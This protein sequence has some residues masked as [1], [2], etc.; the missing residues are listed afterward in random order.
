MRIDLYARCFNEA[1]M[2]PFFFLHYDSLVQR[3]I[4]YDDG[5][6]DSSYELMRLNSKVEVRPM[7][8]YSHPDSRI[9]SALALQDSCW[10]ESRGVADWVIVTDIDEHLYHPDLSTY[11][12]QCRALGVT[13]V[14][15]L[16]FQ[17]LS[18]E[19][20]EQKNLLCRSL[21]KGAYLPQYSKLNIFSPNE[22]DTVNYSPGRHTAA[23]TGYIVAP[24]RDEV[25]LLH[26]HYVGFER[27]RQ[28]YAKILPRQRKKDIE[29]KWGYHYGWSAEK[30]R[31]SWDH[32][33]GRLVDISRPDLRPWDTHEGRRWWERYDRA[34]EGPGRR[35]SMLPWYWLRR[36]RPWPLFLKR[37]WIRS[38]KATRA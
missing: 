3:Y 25:L 20:P 16:G 22:I 37:R 5:S 24:T 17:M 7:P 11:L 1:D 8:P 18:E 33:A 23:P 38:N 4:I 32:V 27:V 13:I 15:A 26:Y 9:S 36:Y 21:T 29:K 12:K 35:L 10:K 2:L 34:G 19:F 31:E 28:R 14:P 6:T 30:L